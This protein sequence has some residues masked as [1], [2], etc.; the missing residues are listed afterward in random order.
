MAVVSQ[1]LAE[2]AA[3]FFA[4]TTVAEACPVFDESES[5]GLFSVAV[6]AA[7]ARC[8]SARLECESGQL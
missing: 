6:A 3:A 8:S 7:A 5:E 4:A 2:L 1:E